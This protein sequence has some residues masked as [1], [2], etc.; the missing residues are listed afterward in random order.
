MIKCKQQQTTGSGANNECDANHSTSMDG[1]KRLARGIYVHVLCHSL[2]ERLF[3]LDA[4]MLLICMAV[5]SFGSYTITSHVHFESMRA[6]DRTSRAN[7]SI[8][9]SHIDEIHDQSLPR[10]LYM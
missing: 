6:S 7:S 3:L 9:A 8:S 4:P 1:Q 10:S 5:F 2:G